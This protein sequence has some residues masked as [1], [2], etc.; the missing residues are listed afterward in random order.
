MV[1]LTVKRGELAYFLLELPVTAQ[2][3]DAITLICEVYNNY[4]KIGR[5]CAEI[6][7]LAK[8]GVTLPP[9][10]QVYYH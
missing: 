4:L 1:R 10:M 2:I 9:N 6:E 8:H 5:I 7:D 3:E